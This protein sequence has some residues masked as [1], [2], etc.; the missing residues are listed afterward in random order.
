MPD[1]PV[2]SFSLDTSSLV[3]SWNRHYQID[4]IPS[5]WDHVE[6]ALKDQTAIATIQVYEEIEKKDDA[7]FEWCKER[8]DFF[9]PIDDV[10]IE[11]LKNLM[12]NFPAI[13]SSGSGRN[14]ADPWVISLAQCYDPPRIVVTEEGTSQ[15]PNNPK[16]PF[17]CGKVG[18]TSCT[19]YQFLKTTGWKES[20]SG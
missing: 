10:H 9:T 20:G 8:K 12:D 15:K 17:I 4:M 18:L 3:N 11:H 16:I 5:I 1:G 2:P 19:F 14:F 13:A 7:L 6:G